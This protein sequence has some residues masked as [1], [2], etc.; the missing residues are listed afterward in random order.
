MSVVTAIES[1]AELSA[2]IAS[3]DRSVVEVLLERD[4]GVADLVARA[5]A[6][7]GEPGGAVALAWQD[8]LSRAGGARGRRR[9]RAVLLGR[10]IHALRREGR[11]DDA[12]SAPLPVPGP[13]LPPEDRWAGWWS[14][15]PPAWPPGL[16]PDR[17]QVLRAARRL[18]LHLRALLLLRD[19]AGLPA[20]EA[21]AIVEEALRERVAPLD[22]DRARG[23]FVAYVDEEIMGGGGT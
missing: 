1:D 15:E 10:V 17:A 20:D 4:H 9:L 2:R 21:G 14:D 7:Q 22:L 6:R 13:F 18:P 16:V 8:L 12:G 11:L 23:A 19:A 5:L 3:G